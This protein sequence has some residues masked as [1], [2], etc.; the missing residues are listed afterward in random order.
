LNNGVEMLALGFG[1]D[2]AEQPGFAGRPGLRG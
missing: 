1:A 2:D